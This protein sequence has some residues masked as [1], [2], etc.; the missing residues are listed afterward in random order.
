MIAPDQ[1]IRKARRQLASGR[2]ALAGDFTD[3]AGRDAYLAAFQAALAYIVEKTGQEPKTH[4]GTRSE[5]ARLAREEARI[6][7]RFVAFLANAY[8]LK[9]WADY[10]GDEPPPRDEAVAA[11]ALADE[12]ISLIAGLITLP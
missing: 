3:S 1:H 4:S 7:R 10:D 9:V 6:V 11:L 5:F 12:M 2:H 8:E